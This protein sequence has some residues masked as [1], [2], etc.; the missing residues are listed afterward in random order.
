MCCLA[1]KMAGLVSFNSC[2]QGCCWS[3]ALLIADRVSISR[4]HGCH[5]HKLSFLMRR[6]SVMLGFQMGDL[7]WPR[8]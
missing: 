4:H 1:L 7:F 6:D 8:S 3:N 5:E 2:H